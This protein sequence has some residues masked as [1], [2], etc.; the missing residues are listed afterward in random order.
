MS[1]DPEKNIDQRS[2]RNRFFSG[3]KNNQDEL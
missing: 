3:K 2:I 1:E